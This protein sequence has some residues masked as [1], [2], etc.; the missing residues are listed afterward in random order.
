MKIER[1]LNELII[2]ARE[3][4]GEADD[5]VGRVIRAGERH[6]DQLRRARERYERMSA[7]RSHK[8]L[9][10]RCGR[11]S[12][13]GILCWQ[14]LD[15]APAAIRHAFRDGRGL[16]GLRLAHDQVRTWIKTGGGSRKRRTSN[17]QLRKLSRAGCR[18]PNEEEAKA[19]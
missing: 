12:S 17:A 11:A 18:T 6:M 3:H 14:C 9:C 19:A 13:A 4:D 7:R 15:E 2:F 1:I 5:F 8:P 16:E 10:K